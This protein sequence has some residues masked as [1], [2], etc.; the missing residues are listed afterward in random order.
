MEHPSITTDEWYN[1][2]EMATMKEMTMI[3]MRVV[4]MMIVMNTSTYKLNCSN[5]EQTLLSAFRQAVDILHHTD[6]ATPDFALRPGHTDQHTAVKHHT[7]S[8][9]ARN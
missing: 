5:I 6:R 4:V 7:T 1:M 2:T 8:A 9:S 3:M